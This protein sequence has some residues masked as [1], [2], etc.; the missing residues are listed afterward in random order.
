MMPGGFM[1]GEV[2]WPVCGVI[3]LEA[4][5]GAAGFGAAEAPFAGGSGEVQAAVSYC[6][7]GV[8]SAAT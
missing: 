2:Q 6:V 5:G 8:S 4:G 7:R 1:A 3:L